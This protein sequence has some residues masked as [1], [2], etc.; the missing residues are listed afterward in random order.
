MISC[1]VSAAVVRNGRVHCAQTDPDTSY[2]VI[3]VFYLSRVHNSR[4]GRVG[5]TADSSGNRIPPR[6][7]MSLL[8]AHRGKRLSASERRLDLYFF[9]LRFAQ[10][11]NRILP[12]NTFH[13]HSQMLL[14]IS[15]LELEL[16]ALRS[17]GFVFF[18]LAAC[19]N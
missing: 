7:S 15:L 18:K 3:I 4:L 16:M 14:K 5:N 6:W 8:L 12:S 11:L 9:N 17:L 13:T 2:V 10:S 19:G 1:A